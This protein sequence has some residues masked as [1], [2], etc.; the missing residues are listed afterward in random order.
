MYL[1]LRRWNHFQD[2]LQRR[3]LP[4]S[5][6]AEQANDLATIDVERN[7]SQHL[8]RAVVGVDFVEFQ[9]CLRHVAGVSSWPSRAPRVS[10]CCLPRY[11]P[12]T[13]GLLATSWYL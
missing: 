10:S 1:T 12:I 4:R 9:Q 11:A 8:D 6:S 5:I 7:V 3:R 13:W 2:R